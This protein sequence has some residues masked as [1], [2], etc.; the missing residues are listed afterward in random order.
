MNSRIHAKEKQLQR[1]DGGEAKGQAP[2]NSDCNTGKK[3]SANMKRMGN[4]SV[5]NWFG[6]EISVY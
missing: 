2:M 3:L 5:L 1:Q 4:N 6:N